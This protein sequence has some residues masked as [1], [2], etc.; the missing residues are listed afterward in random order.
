MTREMRN[1][2]VNGRIRRYGPSRYHHRKNQLDRYCRSILRNLA[3]SDTEV[4]LNSPVYTVLPHQRY[5]PE[6]LSDHRTAHNEHYLKLSRLQPAR[7]ARFAPD[8]TLG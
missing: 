6:R 8:Q 2:W 1:K 4:C 3:W 5:P 7:L